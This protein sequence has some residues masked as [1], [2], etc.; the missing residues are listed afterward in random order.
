MY[1]FVLVC[2]SVDGTDLVY[3]QHS[4]HRPSQPADEPLAAGRHHNHQKPNEPGAACLQADRGYAGRSNYDQSIVQLEPTVQHLHH[5]YLSRFDF[6]DHARRTRQNGRGGT[7]ASVEGGLRFRFGGCRWDGNQPGGATSRSVA[8]GGCG[9]AAS[10]TS[11][12]QD[13]YCDGAEGPPVDRGRQCAKQFRFP[14]LRTGSDRV[15]E[16]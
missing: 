1:S 5:L 13:Q 16:E 11:G 2:G 7:K 12:N 8:G 3:Q 15:G 10:T 14:Q 9:P 4:Y 6:D